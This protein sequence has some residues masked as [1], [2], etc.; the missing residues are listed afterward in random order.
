M[1]M[2]RSRAEERDLRGAKRVRLDPNKPEEAERLA[3]VRLT[4]ADVQVTTDRGL[5]GMG[6]MGGRVEAAIRGMENVRAMLRRIAVTRGDPP[7]TTASGTQ[8]LVGVNANSVM[9]SVV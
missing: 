4:A 3:R 7:S 2:Y 8:S 5:R 1:V 6:A 9:L